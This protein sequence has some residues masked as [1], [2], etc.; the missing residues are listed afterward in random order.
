MFTA[1]G[2]PQV[3]RCVHAYVHTYIHI[4]IYMYDALDSPSGSH[5]SIWPEGSAAQENKGF[6]GILHRGCIELKH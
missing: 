1:F 4:Y 2:V 5:D 6:N 3:V